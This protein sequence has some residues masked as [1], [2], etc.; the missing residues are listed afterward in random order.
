MDNIEVLSEWL[1]SLRIE[2]E[3]SE[4]Y[5]QTDTEMSEVSAPVTVND[6]TQ[7]IMLKS[8]VLNPG[9]F[10]RDQM[11]FEDWWRGIWLYLKSNRIMETNNRITAILVYLRGDVVEIYA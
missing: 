8:I 2:N 5:K 9:W 6:N 10:N 3:A 1:K 7:A 4:E 11:K